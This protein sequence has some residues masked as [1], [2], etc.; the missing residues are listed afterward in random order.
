[1]ANLKDIRTRIDSVKTTRQV[2]S[3]MKMVS[4]ARLKKAQDDI[5]HIRP[6]VMKISE[7]LVDLAGSIEGTESL[8]FA[9]QRE[10]K[11]VSFIVI[12]SN[13]G[14][15]GAFNSNV[16]KETIRQ[17]NTEYLKSGVNV[18]ITTIGSQA[19]KLLKSSGKHVTNEYNE[20]HK[21]LQFQEVSEL[22]NSLMDRFK[23]GE[24]DKIHLVY[25]EFIN[26]GTQNVCCQQFLPIDLP[27]SNEKEQA[28]DYIFEPNQIA[29]VEQLMPS[30]LRTIFWRTLLESVAAEH[31]ARMTSMHKAT[32]NATELLG[33][34]QLT[35]NK[36]RQT[37]ITNEI[38]EIVG[39]AEALKK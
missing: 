37:N 25:N 7:L 9:K 21:E 11:N 14:L 18:E 32:D 19:M 34:L 20:I 13:R 3:A 30:A 38:L 36:A 31:G 27:K 12:S 23:R 6:Y 26:A 10:I 2:T 5:S 22:A 8:E 29:I 28:T 1:M 39:G 33:D 35:Y 15:C 4:A 17:I 24:L 16:V